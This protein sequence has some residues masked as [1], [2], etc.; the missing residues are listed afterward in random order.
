MTDV[1]SR[2]LRNETRS[3]LSRVESGEEVT[4]TVNG[5]PV[6]VLKP[7]GRRPAWFGRA[8]FIR[9]VLPRQADP[10]LAR[11]LAA[12]APDFTDDLTSR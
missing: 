7:V 11:D 4:I 12:L 6:A 8:E 5:R 2:D 10:G 9:R 3:L 1:A